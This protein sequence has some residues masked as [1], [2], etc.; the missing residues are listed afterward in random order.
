MF[1]TD[2]R[3]RVNFPMGLKM[4]IKSICISSLKEAGYAS[5]QGFST[6]FFWSKAHIS[7]GRYKQQEIK[8]CLI[9]Q[10]NISYMDDDKPEVRYADIANV[11]WISPPEISGHGCWKNSVWFIISPSMIRDYKLNDLLK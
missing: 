10:V 7:D 2:N 8:D 11:Y 3:G 4:L 9:I 5:K 1:T 6:Y